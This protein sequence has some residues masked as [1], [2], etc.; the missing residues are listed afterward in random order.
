MAGALGLRCRIAVSR[1]N[2]A[3]TKADMLRND[4]LR[5]I[6]VDP[7]T[8]EVRDDGEVVTSPPAETLA[9]SQRYFPGLAMPAS[10]RSLIA[11]LQLADSSFPMGA[12]AHSYGL[13]QLV[14]DGMVRDAASLEAFV[15]SIVS[16]QLAPA[17]AR[18]AASAC[19]A[20]AL[21]GLETGAR[22]RPLP[23]RHARPS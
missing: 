1:N 17:E 18:A 16:L 4:A 20:A 6:D 22:D 8:Y 23:P 9:L 15:D 7:E 12:F 19:H 3:L 11:L 5:A 21:G 14:R 10:T 2:R 13:E